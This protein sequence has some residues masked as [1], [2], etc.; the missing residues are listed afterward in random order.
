[1]K[2]TAIET[3]LVDG[4]WDVWG[5]LKMS[6]DEGLIG[7]S[8]FSHARSRKGLHLL[9]ADMEE[10]VLGL[11]PTHPG[12][13]SA[14]LTATLRTPPEGLRAMAIGSIENACLD[15][16]GK[17]LGVPVSQLL[18]GRLRDRLPLYWSH[19]GMYRL[20]K[21]ELFERLG[22]AAPIRSLG[23]IAGLAAEVAGRG[24]GGL[25]T[26]L[27]DFPERSGSAGGIRAASDRYARNIDPEAIAGAV[28]LMSAFREGGGPG[29]ELMLDVNFNFSAEGMRRLARALEPLDLT[30]L[31]MDCTDAEQL[32]RVRAETQT[33]IASLETVLGRRALKPYLLAGAVD[34]AIIDPVYNGVLEARRMAA[35]IEAFD[36]N[37]AA[38]N[39]HGPLTGAMA[40]QFCAAIPN[41]RFLEYDPDAV[42]WRDELLTPGLAITAGK[43]NVPTGP[44]WGCDIDETVARRHLAV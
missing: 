22:I 5:F 31:E 13:V 17:A 12:H 24:Y 44:G 14:H 21:P 26:N 28:A 36:I 3:L 39:A 10:M 11:D 20:R 37:V 6:T 4:G 42:P 40:A 38:H 27:L 30:W 2:I 25:K 7:W 1:M 43:L 8:E 15:I 9:I 41:F 32:A 19:C 34:V 33:P 29:M 18:G 16:A 35:M 23:D